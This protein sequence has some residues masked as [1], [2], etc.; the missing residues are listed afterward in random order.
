MGCTAG[1]PMK[2][3]WDEAAKGCYTT[4]PAHSASVSIA[5]HAN[6]SKS[7]PMARALVNRISFQGL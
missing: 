4:L 2:V 1:A 6:G 3:W 5:V 7:K